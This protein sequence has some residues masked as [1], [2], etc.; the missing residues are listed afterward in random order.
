VTASGADAAPEAATSKP[1]DV[2]RYRFSNSGSLAMFA[3]ILR[4]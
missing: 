2:M 4:A 3:A 1:S